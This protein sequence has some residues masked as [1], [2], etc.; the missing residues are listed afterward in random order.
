MSRIGIALSLVA[1]VVAA[2]WLGPL[3]ARPVAGDHLHA[4]HAAHDAAA[5]SD[6]SMRRA[7][8]A[9]WATHPR[10]GSSSA[11]A[12]LSG[13]ADAT[14]NVSGLTFDADGSAATAIDTVRISA[15]QT[16]LW[17]WV[18]G[19]H[20]V[21]S[22]TGNLD[23][24]AG[25]VFDQPSDAAHPQFFF[26]FAS[27]ETVPFF[28]SPHE[29]FNMKGVVIVTAPVGATPRGGGE[30][31]GFVS[32]PWPNPSSRG[33]SFRFTLGEGGRVHA[34]LVDARGRHVATLVDREY[35]A[36][37]HEV[38]WDGRGTAGRLGAGVYALRLRVPG[39][40]GTRRLVL[41]R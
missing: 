4:G 2:A 28:C 16:V 10:V 7:A 6:E 15:G 19:I 23:P 11:G 14:F 22:G 41:G 34:D 18:N 38:A 29:G 31:I 35:P 5:M 20:T 27:P 12:R 37:L 8:D 30:A 1:L 33:A 26:T 32:G 39:Y 36:G 9:Y 21:T 13:G 40:V 24:N 25:L 3:R 17:Q